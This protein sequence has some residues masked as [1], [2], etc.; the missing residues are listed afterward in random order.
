MKKLFKE[1]LEAHNILPYKEN[2]WEVISIDHSEFS[3]R[4]EERKKIR[5]GLKSIG[6]GI[7]IY[8][9]KNG[10]VLYVGE[11]IVRDRL[12]EHYKKSHEKREK[13]SPRYYF[14]HSRK[15]EVSVYFREFPNKYER[16]AVEAM[17]TTVLEPKYSEWLHQKT[18]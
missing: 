6:C 9:N 7:Y 10:D 16:L 3:N 4:V 8:T 17:L 12:M 15:E 2:K 5:N 14:F 13:G 11:G 1:F 18:K